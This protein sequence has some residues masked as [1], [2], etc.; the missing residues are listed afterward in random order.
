MRK[1][2]GH[3]YQSHV[4]ELV[5]VIKNL[6]QFYCASQPST[7]RARSGSE[8]MPSDTIDMLVDNDDEELEN[9][10]YES[11]R[12]DGAE[13][14]ELDKY[15]ADAP[16]RISGQFDILAWWKNQVDEYP[17][18][19]QIARDLLAVQ[20]ST[21]A[22]ESTFSAG[23]R[24]IDPFRSRLDPEMVEALV[25]TKDWVAATKRGNNYSLNL[26]LVHEFFI[27]VLC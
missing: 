6:Y 4:D 13:L 7:S 27:I 21:I 14:S 9:Y 18:L 8:H 19:S 17:I 24:V 1:F 11:S 23:G 12:P 22:S 16:L 3:A 2:H 5:D 20:V 10:L 25:C 15:M 26:V